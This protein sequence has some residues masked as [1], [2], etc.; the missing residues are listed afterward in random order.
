[1]PVSR[2]FFGFLSLAGVVCLLAFPTSGMSQHKPASKAPVKP[3]QQPAPIPPPAPE[4]VKLTPE[5]MPAVPPQV[6]YRDGQLSIAA[7]NSTLSDI[8]RAVRT[9]TGAAIDV[10]ANANSRVAAKLGPGPAR[11]VLATLLNGS[12]FNYVMLGTAAQPNALARVILTPKPS[13]APADA[14]QSPAAYSPG[15]NQPIYANPQPQ[16]ATDDS[17][18]DNQE[19]PPDQPE[20][21]QNGANGQPGVKTPEQLLQELQQQQLLMQ[22]RLQQAN[23]PSGRIPEPTP[24]PQQ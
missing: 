10:P 1:M 12:L 15:M 24:P 4:P 13:G 21:P 6:T 5:Q 11:E 2:H 19:E 7:E 22:Q 18:N 23:S 17:E 14:S 9:Q 16:I 8:L 3:E 20:T